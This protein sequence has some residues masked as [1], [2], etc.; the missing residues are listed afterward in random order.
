M[1]EHLIRFFD[2]SHLP[3]NLQKVVKPFGDLA[4]S[5][6]EDLQRSPE[7]SAALRKLIEA[8]DCAVR[9]RIMD[10]EGHG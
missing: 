8:K 6:C 4:A 7:R 3:P 10:E 2:S 5:L 1:I 9:A